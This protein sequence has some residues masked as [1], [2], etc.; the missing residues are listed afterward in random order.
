MDDALLAARLL[1]MDGRVGVVTQPH[2]LFGAS[3]PAVISAG[4]STSMSPHEEVGIEA[5]VDD[6]TGMALPVVLA[7]PALA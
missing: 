6:E 3:Q 7:V 1:H 2:I 4:R 5:S